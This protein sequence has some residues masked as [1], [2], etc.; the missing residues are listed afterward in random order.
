MTRLLINDHDHSQTRRTPFSIFK[1]KNNK[2]IECLRWRGTDIHH[3]ILQIYRSPRKII[4]MFIMKCVVE[5]PLEIFITNSH[6]MAFHAFWCRPRSLAFWPHEPRTENHK[7]MPPFLPST[8]TCTR[9]AAAAAA[10]ARSTNSNKPP[11]TPKKWRRTA[12]RNWRCRTISLGNKLI[13]YQIKINSL[14]MK[15]KKAG[16]GII[17]KKETIHYMH[18]R[19]GQHRLVFFFSFLFYFLLQMPFIP[20]SCRCNIA[21]HVFI[22]RLLLIP[23]LRADDF[24]SF[25]PLV[26]LLLFDRFFSIKCLTAATSKNHHAPWRTL[27]LSLSLPLFLTTHACTCNI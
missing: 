26:L 19:D 13:E 24:F 23:L 21:Q 9:A 10:A 3:H 14:K 18:L 8:N 6:Q 27:S 25:W 11:P 4:R 7:Q 2:I 1:R 12:R 22:W 15:K 16:G 17:W 5:L 20:L